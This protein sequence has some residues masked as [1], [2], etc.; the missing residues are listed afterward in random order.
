MFFF[1]TIVEISVLHAGQ[2]A[3]AIGRC[4]EIVLA[5]DFEVGAAKQMDVDLRLLVFDVVGDVAY[6]LLVGC[7]LYNAPFRDADGDVIGK[8]DQAVKTFQ[9]VLK[10]KDVDLLVFGQKISHALTEIPRFFRAKD[11]LTVDLDAGCGDV[12]LLD[13]GNEL[14]LPF[15]QGRDGLLLA[16]A[17]TK[18]QGEQAR[19]LNDVFLL[20][21]LFQNN[22]IFRQPEIIVGLLVDDVVIAAVQ[23]VA[24]ICR[25]KGAK[26]FLAAI[27]SGK[28][29]FDVTP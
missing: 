23:A 16:L 2:P 14:V 8:F 13:K 6:I 21:L 25:N 29:N 17:G 26:V 22:I 10:M 28:M 20:L 19:I 18:H 15:G 11:F 4:A 24:G 3:R 5:D 1:D 7:G 27:A 9:A 12:V